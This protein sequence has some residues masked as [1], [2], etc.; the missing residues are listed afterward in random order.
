MKNFTNKNLLINKNTIK[1]ISQE[2]NFKNINEFFEIKEDGTN[3]IYSLTKKNLI[4]SV[5]FINFCE[6]ILT[7]RKENVILNKEMERFERVSVKI[8][9]LLKILKSIRR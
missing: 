5:F 4:S 7:N 1:E 9:K 2:M 8:N 3:I 6:K